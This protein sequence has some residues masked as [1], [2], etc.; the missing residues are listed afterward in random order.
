[1]EERR[2]KVALA[3]PLCCLCNKLVRIN[4]LE[5]A[6]ELIGIALAWDP[7]NKV[8]NYIPKSLLSILSPI[9]SSVW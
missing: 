4:G 2:S 1:M 9:P 8:M 3:L 6:V 5:D 7:I